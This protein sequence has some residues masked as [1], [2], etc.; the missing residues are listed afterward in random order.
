M[1]AQGEALDLPLSFF[2]QEWFF[3]EEILPGNSEPASMFEV[4]DEPS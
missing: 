1:G 4:L 3:S 2:S